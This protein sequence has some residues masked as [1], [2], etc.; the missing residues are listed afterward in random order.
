MLK[1]CGVKIIGVVRFGF[2]VIGMMLFSYW[3]LL[4]IVDV[5]KVMN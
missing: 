4:V 5:V 2:A 3:D 1:R